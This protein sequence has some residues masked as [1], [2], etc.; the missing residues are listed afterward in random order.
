MNL[1]GTSRGVP[2]SLAS[3]IMPALRPLP[4]WPLQALLHLAARHMAQRHPSVFARLRPLGPVAIAIDVTDLPFVFEFRPNSADHQLRLIERGAVG[5]AVATI[6]GPL[7]PLL[8]LLQGQCDG[9][10]L[11]FSRVLTIEGDTAAVLALRNAIDN[12]DVDLPADFAALFGPARG[13]IERLVRH[14]ERQYFHLRQR[15]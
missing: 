9:D 1:T 6:R 11:F 4:R 7:L 10:A 15:V 3:K 12:A 8:T 2:P 14:A 13:I 5:A